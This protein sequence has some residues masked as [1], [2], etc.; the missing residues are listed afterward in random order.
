MAESYNYNTLNWVKGEIDETLNQARQALEAYVENKDDETQLQFCATYL[1]QVHGTLKMVEL[2]GAVMVAEEM[3]HI[4]RALLEKKIAKKEDA[5]EVLMRAILQLPD[6]LEHLQ[7]G[8]K[9]VPLALLPLLNDMRAT[10]GQSLLSESAFF[11]PNL[12]VATPAV[13]SPV[14]E[15]VAEL[16]KRLRHRYQ[17]GLVSW[18]RDRNVE[19]ALQQL[20][21]VV[22]EIRRALREPVPRQLFW[23]AAG[24]IEAL[25][26]EGLAASVSTKL[27]LGQ[28]DRKIKGL[29]DAG[30]AALVNQSQVELIK[31]LLFYVA[32][33]KSRGPIVNAVRQAFRLD[34]MLSATVTEDEKEAGLGG[35]NLGVLETVATVVHEDLTRIKDD[36]DLFMRS[37]SRDLATLQPVA[38]GLKKIADTLGMLGLGTQRNVVVEQAAIVGDMIE[39]KL[40]PDDNAF[41]EMASGF[42]FIESSLSELKQ[43]GSSGEAQGSAVL[44]GLKR[45]QGEEVE[46]TG[47]PVNATLLQESDQQE[48]LK[49]VIAEAKTDMARVKDA[50][51]SFISSPWEHE[52]LL[53]VPQLNRQVRGSMSMLSLDDA[54]ELLSACNDYISRELIDNHN[55]PNQATLD[56]L[57][58][59]ITSIEY[60]LEALEEK[61][62]DCDAI[63]E[64]ARDRV[65]KLGYPVGEVSTDE[66]RLAT[67]ESE[68]PVLP[69]ADAATIPGGMAAQVAAEPDQATPASPATPAGGL[70]EDELDDEIIDIFLEE[71]AEEMATL[72]EYFPRWKQNPDDKDALTTVRRSFHTLKG[73]GRM[74]GATNIGEFAWAFENLLN[75]IIDKTIP[76]SNEALQLIDQGLVVLPELVEQ[77]RGGSAPSSDIEGL[78]DAAHVMSKRGSLPRVETGDMKVPAE[79]EGP[80]VIASRESVAASQPVKSEE[81]E[82]VVGEARGIEPVLLEIFT[83]ESERH[84]G[85]IDAFIELCQS[86]GEHCRINDDVARAVH[87]LH[88]SAHMAAITDIAEVS[89]LL[90]KYIKLLQ[91]NGRAVD[92]TTTELMT[93]CSTAIR[94]RVGQL[95][96]PESSTDYKDSLLDKI[97]VL[98]ERE[99]ALEPE[100][101]AGEE[102]PAESM[103]SF[104]SPLTAADDEDFDAE[105]LDIFIEEGVEILDASEITLQNWIN[106]QDDQGLV[107]QLQR[108]I[109]TL[110]GGARMAGIV[111]MGD[112]SHGLE[113]MIIAITEGR[114]PVSKKMFD[115]IQQSHDKLVTMLEQVRDN[116]PL[117]SEEALVAKLEALT[118]GQTLDDLEEA[119]A[120]IEEPEV[121][122]PVLAEIS[123]GDEVV[124]EA[125]E[126]AAEPL[127]REAAAVV[128][129]EIVIM[130]PLPEP[131]ETEAEPVERQQRGRIQHEQIRVRADLLDELVNFA[132]EVSI[133]RSRIEQQVGSFRF[134]L[135]EMEQT[136]SRL[137]EQ[138]RRFEIE[139]EAQIM[140]RFE[141]SG[142]EYDEDF[143]PLEMDRFSNMQQLS[144]ALLES[145]NDL[146]SIQ[147]LLDNQTRESETLLL[148]QSRINTELQEG[149]MRTRMVPFSLHL[150]RLRR[151]VRQTGSEV[152]K[153][154]NLVVTGEEGELDRNVLDRVL[155][156]LEHMLRNAVDHGMETRAKRKKAGKPETGTI[157][158]GISREGTEIVIRISD[159]GQGIDLAAIR[160][161]ALERG[162]MKEGSDLTDKEVLRFILESGFSTAQKVTQ[163]SGRGVGMDVVNSEIKQLGGS[164]QIDTVQGQGS[165]FTVRL[166][167]TLSVNKALLVNVGEDIYAIPLSSIEGVVRVGHE[168]LE[169]FYSSKDARYSYGGNDYR[170]MH[171]G[172]QLGLNQPLLP[173]PGGKLPVL[174]ARAGDHRI[175][176]QVEGLR[177]SRE[178]VV[179]PVGPQISTVQAI[180]GATI[181]ADGRVALILD[182]SALVYM[183]VARPVLQTEAV[184][185]EAGRPPVAANRPLTVMVVDD[186]ITVRKVTTRLLER[187]NMHVITAKDGV[188]AVAVLQE[189]IPDIFLLDIEMPR[190]DG[191]E[192]ATH[193]RNDE[194]LKN[195]PIIMI[196]SRT[197]DKHRQ[198]AMDIGVNCYLGKPFQEADLLQNIKETLNAS[199]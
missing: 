108:E 137:R 118:A 110:K 187:N 198:R 191:Y 81:P 60:Y 78:Q 25:K 42:I 116:R 12:S 125:I 5:Y 160:N 56:T 79:G 101:P 59:A 183:D 41:M 28:V 43:G 177:G 53:D 27:L 146:S 112:L 94:Q 36:I 135:T 165:R 119:E 143:D 121:S 157:H 114:V 69:D 58:D 168:Q 10:C 104:A 133:Y 129:E 26:D 140:Y 199:R 158:I 85:D 131:S 83:K 152:K 127:A 128:E 103:A 32:N 161:K 24:L 29:I 185:D 148:Q 195:I 117:Q 105:L 147:G 186:S 11:S 95:A 169:S 2:Y 54:A 19:Q 9:D 67:T 23:V 73:S 170:F 92:Q 65:N 82:A 30:E 139:T 39:G 71:A 13:D 162:L 164:L 14:D 100:S 46:E 90:E 153:D 193:I 145:L 38:D 106:R 163:I 126:T 173:G 91:V 111:P 142:T 1:H 21:E 16:A 4:A 115:L 174:L 172:S 149:L 31:N 64:I 180:S 123:A 184:T 98:Y 70:E 17:M 15:D 6:Y 138:M 189:Q 74:V 196:T 51:V 97:G 34:E 93:E 75:R 22:H 61:R 89:S 3:E 45:L 107:E 66:P 18:F 130:P 171:L 182:I 144:R 197:G 151:L 48:L 49:A 176:L 87:T 8:N 44:Q 113:T 62:S 159:D 99:L 37:E 141:E 190:M 179:K 132:G 84:L 88:G 52:L 63:L 178:I 194:M 136:I 155:P 102:W 188:D 76:S 80:G 86:Q 109:H 33:A 50:I 154:V 72:A 124:K 134:N 175:A 156:P 40:P 77:F 181:L 122:K 57:A 68:L 166:P 96:D 120:P 150:P 167:L 7:A 47:K 55:I 35:V 192:L 20:A